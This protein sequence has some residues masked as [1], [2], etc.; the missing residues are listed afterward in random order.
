MFLYSLE[1]F[2]LIELQGYDE[3]E[4]LHQV[5][6][7]CPHASPFPIYVHRNGSQETGDLDAAY[8]HEGFLG[9]IVIEPIVEEE[10]KC[11][12]VKDI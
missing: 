9:P 11:K 3:L 2:R 8:N 10:G 5:L 12:T 7:N 4:F 6:P 1:R